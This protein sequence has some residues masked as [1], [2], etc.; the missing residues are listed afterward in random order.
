MNHSVVDGVG[1][2]DEFVNLWGETSGSLPFYRFLIG[3][4]SK[5][6]T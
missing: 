4:L 6:K 1:A 5:L 2:M 3:T